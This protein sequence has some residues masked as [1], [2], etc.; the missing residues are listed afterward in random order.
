[1]FDAKF[2]INSNPDFANM[3]CFSFSNAEERKGKIF[4]C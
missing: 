1:M 2:Y 3:P 4:G